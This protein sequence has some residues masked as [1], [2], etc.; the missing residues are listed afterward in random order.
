[1]KEQKETE[2][3]LWICSLSYH[4]FERGK[5]E[6]MEDDFI[7]KEVAIGF[8]MSFYLFF[9]DVTWVVFFFFNFFFL[10]RI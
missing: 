3:I 10:D 6:Q 1:M 4:M 2:G 7:F 9:D 5:E 8:W